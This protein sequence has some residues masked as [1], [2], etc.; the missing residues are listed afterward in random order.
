MA[1]QQFRHHRL[2]TLYLD[3]LVYIHDIVTN[4]LSYKGLIN[5]YNPKVKHITSSRIAM[6]LSWILPQS[7]GNNS[8]Q[9][10]FTN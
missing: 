9:D 10:F 8:K 3:R 1:I 2:K 5:C 6:A 4:P 7:Q